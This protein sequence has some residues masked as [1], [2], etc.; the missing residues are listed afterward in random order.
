MFSQP[1]QWSHQSNL[2]WNCCIQTVTIK[3]TKIKKKEMKWNI[4]KNLFYSFIFVFLHLVI[5]IKIL[6]METF[7]LK[8]DWWFHC[9]ICENQKKR[10]NETFVKIW[11][12]LSFLFSFIFVFLFILVIFI[13]TIWMEQF[14]LKLDGWLHCNICENQKKKKTKWTVCKICFIF[15]FFFLFF[16]FILVIFLK[17]I[18]MEQFQLKLDWWLH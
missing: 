1:L 7:Q 15:I 10:R 5:L 11:F 13:K 4:N 3:P 6:W 16:V 9:N 12:I 2:S 8:L 14:Q 17:T 18:W